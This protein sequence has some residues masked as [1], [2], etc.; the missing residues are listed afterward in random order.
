MVNL[1]A[2]YGNRLFARNEVFKPTMFLRVVNLVIVNMIAVFAITTFLD[3]AFGV[4]L[5]VLVIFGIAQALTGWVVDVLT[6]RFNMK[7]LIEVEV[8][9]YLETFKVPLDDDNSGCVE[10]YLLEAA[11]DPSLN[12]EMNILAAMNYTSVI[13]LM[14]VQ[15]KWDRYYYNAWLAVSPEY[16][17]RGLADRAT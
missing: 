13:C 4:V 17:E 9:H 16:V 1:K 14:S 5:S 15:P 10:D 3:L 7:K 2:M 6:Y 8:R 12:H 11:F